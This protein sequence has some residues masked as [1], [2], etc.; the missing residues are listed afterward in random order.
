MVFFI[1]KEKLALGCSAL[2]YKVTISG[3]VMLF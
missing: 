2:D 3:K 1:G